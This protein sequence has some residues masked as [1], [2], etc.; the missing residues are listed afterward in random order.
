MID[1]SP[2]QDPPLPD[3]ALGIVRGVSYGL[4]RKPE[5]FVA[6][7]RSLGATL[8]R[9]YVYWSQIEREPGRY[10]FSV[11]DTFLNELNGSE[12]VWITVSSSSPWA[13]RQPTN[14]LPASP[15]KDLAL[16]RL[17]RALLGFW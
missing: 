9:I 17:G 4:F 12:K 5:P 15:P 14:F 11:V 13:T 6:E 2:A 3:V 10:D 7:V 16:G 1:R 8:V